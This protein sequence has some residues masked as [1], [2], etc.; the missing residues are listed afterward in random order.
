[1]F[2]R[3]GP[4]RHRVGRRARASSTSTSGSSGPRWPRRDL[5]AGVVLGLPALGPA[6]RRLQHVP[7]LHARADARAR[8]RPRRFARLYLAALLRAPPAPWRSSP[9]RSPW[10]A[11]G[12]V[13]GLM[14]PRSSSCAPAG[15]PFQTFIGPLILLNLV[16]SFVIPNN[17]IG[18]HVGGLIGGAIAALVLIALERRRLPSWSAYP[19]LVVLALGFGARRPGLRRR[20][21]LGPAPGGAPG[22][23]PPHRAGQLHLEDREPR[24]GTRSGCRRWPSSSRPSTSRGPGARTWRRRPRRRPARGRPG[25]A[26]GRR[27]RPPGA[28]AGRRSRT[29]CRRRPR[30]PRPPRWPSRPGWSAPRRTR[31]RRSRPR[32]R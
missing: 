21:G 3:L 1:M 23:P 5:A 26:R 4:L 29:A 13:C 16:S 19:A 11:S 25:A 2:L 32:A 7:A 9:R 27:A 6:A 30:A 12:A 10:G 31:G 8:A 15:R 22:L 17:S 24:V 20:L 14:A 18:G 28:P